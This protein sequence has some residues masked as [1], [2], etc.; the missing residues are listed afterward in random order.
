MDMCRI[1]VQ[2]PIG[3]LTLMGT[4][5]ALTEIAFGG[6]EDGSEVSSPVLV[7]AAQELAEYFDRK[8]RAFSVPLAPQGTEFQ[9]KVWNALRE[10]PYGT[11]VSY[12][13]IAVRLGKPGA[14]IAVGQANSRNPIPI[15]IPCHRIIGAGGKLVG[16][17][18]GLEIK[19]ALLAV[20]GVL[21]TA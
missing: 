2:S 8:R 1:W 12:K 4:E 15:I 7:Q 9:K 18:G 19:K 6:V 21:G 16:Y 13:D 14:A 17:T 20:E 3:P 5:D 10:V 11:T